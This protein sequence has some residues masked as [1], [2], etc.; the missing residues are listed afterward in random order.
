M[1][2][3]FSVTLFSINFAGGKEICKR[4]NETKITLKQIDYTTLISQKRVQ[5]RF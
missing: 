5:L 3:N 2:R 1:V 4:I